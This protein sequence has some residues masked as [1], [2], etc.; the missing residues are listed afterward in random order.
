MSDNALASGQTFSL[1]HPFVRSVWTNWDEGGSWNE[2]SWKPG[3]EFETYVDD[4]YAVCHGVGAVT[5]TVI[6]VH[7]LPRP[8]PSR[9]FYTRLW[10]SPDGRTFGKKNLLNTTVSAFRR[11]CSV[12]LFQKLALPVEEVGD[13]PD[14]EKAKL[15]NGGATIEATP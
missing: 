9:V 12:S 2:L 7:K 15:L 5:Y 10:T 11:R 6:D 3:V 1:P 14:Y 4:S 13:L 8:Y